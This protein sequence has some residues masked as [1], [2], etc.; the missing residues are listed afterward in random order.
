MDITPVIPERIRVLLGSPGSGAPTV[1][2]SFPDYIKNVASS[3]IFPTWPEEALRANILAQISFAL[4][5]VF[6]EYYPSRG[7]DF[8]ITNDT[9][10]DQSFIYGREYYE[11]VSRIVD[12]IFNNYVSRRGSIEPLFTLYCDGI[13]T[14]CSGLSQWGSVEL[15]DEGLDALEIL[16]RYYGDDIEIVNNAPIAEIR[17]SNPIRPLSVG[18]AGSDVSFI[19]IRL[20]RISSNYPAIPK[21]DPVDGVFGKE[22]EDAVRAFQRIFGLDRDGVVGKATW[23]RIQF[24]FNSVKRLSELDSEG[25]S[26]EEIPTQFPTE[27]KTGDRGIYVFAAQYFL[28]WISTFD[29]VVPFVAFDGIYGEETARAVS[30]FQQAYGLRQTGVVDNDTWNLLYDVY[31]GGIAS[32]SEEQLGGGARPF[33]GNALKIGSEGEDVAVLQS[34]INAAASVYAAIPEVE[35]DGI[36]GENTQNAVFAAQELFEYPVTGVVGPVLW[37]TLGIIYSAVSGGGYRAPGQFS[38]EEMA[39]EGQNGIQR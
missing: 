25:L 19:Q 8:D 37:D 10:L 30:A 39:A 26:F 1:E 16:K 9:A 24:I 22:T 20:N 36:F 35:E 27:L 17:P 7:Y 31:R 14:T 11:N 32:V 13:R 34:Y 15:A 28:R 18:D 2:V 23:Y 33:P 21:I 5:R 6:T 4:N 38:G 29:P 3:E 12:E